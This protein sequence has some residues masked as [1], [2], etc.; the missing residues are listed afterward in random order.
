MFDHVGYRLGK[1]I[2]LH[3]DRDHV[4]RGRAIREGPTS[5]SYIF[6]PLI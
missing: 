3:V 5:T 6:L 4:G 2:Q 1:V